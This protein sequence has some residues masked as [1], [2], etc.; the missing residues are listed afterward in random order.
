MQDTIKDP[1]RTPLPRALIYVTAVTCGIL[2]AMMV[3]IVLAHSG[4][5]LAGAWRTLL[6]TQVLQTRSASVWWLM[7]GA[8]F[9]TGAIVA[10]ALSRLPLPWRRLRLMRWILGAAIV[11]ALGQ[12]GHAAKLASGQS[13]PAHVAASLGALV[14]AALVAQFGAYFAVKR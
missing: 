13:V 6:T 4:I 3:E 11:Y 5:A 1:P 2:A 9:L 8:A 14:A 10:A 12:V 7:A